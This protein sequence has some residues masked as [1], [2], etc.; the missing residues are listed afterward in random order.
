MRLTDRQK[1]GLRLIAADRQ[2][3]CGL[4]IA[5]QLQGKGLIILDKKYS[6]SGV[7]RVVWWSAKLTPYGQL[8]LKGLKS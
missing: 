4:Y 8:I 2:F 7:S 3:S 1:N 5:K 6:A